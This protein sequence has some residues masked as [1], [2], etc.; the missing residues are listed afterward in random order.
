MVRI[1]FCLLLCS[2]SAVAQ[3]QLILLRNDHVVGRFTEGEYLRAVMR[4]GSKREGIIIEL[5]E[6][7]AITSNDTIPFNKI[8]KIEIPKG[9]RRGI[10]PLF[11]SL[12]LGIGVTLIGI[13]ALNSAT[14][15]TASGGIDPQIAKTSAILIAAG[16]ILVFIKPKYRRVNNGTFLRT[17]DYKSRWYKNPNYGQ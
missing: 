16:S 4:D 2:V 5:H 17:I 11:G 3:K 10:S 9:K 15:H 14:G 6:F 13:D 12:M 8:D 7:L 1:L